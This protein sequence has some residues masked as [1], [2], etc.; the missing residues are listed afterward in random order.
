V[1]TIRQRKES[2]YH[3]LVMSGNYTVTQ[4]YMNVATLRNPKCMTSRP[5]EAVP[6]SSLLREPIT[7]PYMAHVDVDS[8]EKLRESCMFYPT[9]EKNLNMRRT[10]QNSLRASTNFT[11]ER[12]AEASPPKERRIRVKEAVPHPRSKLFYGRGKP[13]KDLQSLISRSRNVESRL[14]R[15]LLELEGLNQEHTPEA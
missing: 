2:F 9:G 8:P 10:I 6:H 13:S 3:L 11:V 7:I 4:P 15:T 14:D 12:F 1:E 5:N